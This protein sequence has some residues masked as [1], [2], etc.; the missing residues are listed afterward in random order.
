MAG[1]RA[2]KGFASLL[3]STTMI[4]GESTV[5][6]EDPPMD[7]TMLHA[8]Y[9]ISPRYDTS[10]PLLANTL[11]KRVYLEAIMRSRGREIYA[12]EKRSRPRGSRYG[13]VDPSNSSGHLHLDANFKLRVIL[14]R[15]EN[16]KGTLKI[17]VSFVTL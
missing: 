17:S 16:V 8:I 2:T 6:R 12:R 7:R 5:N 9:N 4:R 3:L 10:P 11:A 15:I 13:V 1:V 14:H